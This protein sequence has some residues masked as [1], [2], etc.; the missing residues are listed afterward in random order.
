MSEKRLY[1]EAISS[2]EDSA[3]FVFGSPTD[4]SLEN[5]EYLIVSVA[6]E[7]AVD[8][9]NQNFECT[10]HLSITQAKKLRNFLMEHLE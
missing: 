6:E 1:F 5:K 8:S 4:T 3:T 10:I 7:K 2:W 9:Y